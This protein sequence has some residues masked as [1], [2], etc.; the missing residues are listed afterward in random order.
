MK[1]LPFL[2]E[3]LQS[4]LCQK[5]Y[6]CYEHRISLKQSWSSSNQWRFWPKCISD[7]WEFR[8]I[9]DILKQFQIFCNTIFWSILAFV[10]ARQ[11]RESIFG[12]VFSIFF[13]MSKLIL[14]VRIDLVVRIFC[15]R[16]LGGLFIIWIGS[17][18]FLN[19]F[20][21]QSEQSIRIFADCIQR[22][23]LLFGF[24]RRCNIF[25][26]WG[27][28]CIKCIRCISHSFLYWGSNF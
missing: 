28:R 24:N 8:Q 17:F 21:Q 14:W 4:D 10:Q 7:K 27:S 19:H 11:I 18:I 15:N 16:D 6:L 5:Q 12:Q 1:N 20:R 22:R 25:G 23:T 3:R 9:Q 2:L 13:I 26:W